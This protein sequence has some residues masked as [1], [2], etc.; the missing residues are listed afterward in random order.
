MEEEGPVIFVLPLGSLCTEKLYKV[1]V[2]NGSN[3]A[4]LCAFSSINTGKL[5]NINLWIFSGPQ[6]PVSLSLQFPR[7]C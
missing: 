4:A 6:L 2:K 7:Q 1:H 3:I 5:L